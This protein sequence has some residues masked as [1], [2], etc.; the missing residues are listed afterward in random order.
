MTL[1]AQPKPASSHEFAT[2]GGGCFWCMEAVFQRLPGI[3][4][5]TSGY[6]GG[7]TANPTYE[8]VC[9]HGTGHAE[10]IRVEFDPAVISYEKVLEVFFE[11]HDP[12]TLNRQGADE[13]DQ[14]RSVILYENEAQQVAAGKAKL[15]A[16]AN[17]SDPIVTEIVPLKKFW[18]AEDYHQD[19]FNQHPNQG[20]CT[21]VIKPKVKKLQDHGVIQK[22]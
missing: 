7:T 14:Y 8:E 3:I 9:G 15:A 21:F 16:Q 2:F 10:V 11:A 20:Y 4:H 22:K 6:A 19:Y 17:Y 1:Q 18:R 13:G 12:T 5:S